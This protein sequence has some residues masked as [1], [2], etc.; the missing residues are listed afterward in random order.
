MARGLFQPWF[1]SNDG[2]Q[3]APRRDPDYFWGGRF[4]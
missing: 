2:R 1:D 4:N 3:A